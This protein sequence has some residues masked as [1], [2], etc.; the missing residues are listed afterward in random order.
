MNKQQ[1]Q[2]IEGRDALFFKNQVVNSE[3]ESQVRLF[4]RFP[5]LPDAN[6]DGVLA[7]LLEINQKLFRMQNRV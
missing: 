3:S 4:S 5:T 1:L 6:I 7:I 2:E